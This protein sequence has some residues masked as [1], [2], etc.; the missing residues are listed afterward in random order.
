MTP[1]IL[2]LA[3]ALMMHPCGQAQ[4]P[5]DSVGQLSGPAP[6]V[7]VWRGQ[8]NGLPAVTLVVTDEGGSLSGAVLFFFQQRPSVHDP[9]TA[10][11]GLPEPVLHPSFDG[12]SLVFQVSHRRA[13]P[14]RTLH[15]APVQFRLTLTGKDTAELA[16]EKEGPGLPMV[17]TD[18]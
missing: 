11:P 7:G 4:N 12:K 15:D 14:P 13:H 3:L 5:S 16:N 10:S 8:M 6:I 2:T 17:R 18:F 1:R 9:Y